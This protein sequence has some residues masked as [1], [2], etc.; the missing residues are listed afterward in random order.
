V[1]QGRILHLCGWDQKFVLS[2]RDL[3]HAHFA[4]GRHKFIIYGSVDQAAL[5]QS[6]DTVV[7]GSLLKNIF[8]LSTAMQ[9]AEKI[10]LHGLFS[11]HLLYV[12]ALQPWLLKKCHW[13]IW[14]GD[15]Y[16]HQAEVK[17]LRWKKN[18][19]FRRLVIQRLGYLLTYIPGDVALARQ[20]YGATGQYQEC[21]MY[22]SNIFKELVIP[23]KTGS[24]VNILVGNSADPTNNHL[25][26]FEKLA[27]FKSENIMI[28]CPLS[29]GGVDNDYVKQ[30]AEKGRA[31]FGDRFVA[32]T[33][34]MP[35]SKYLAF[36]GQIDIAVFAHK[37]QQGMGNTITL[38]GLGKKVYM[39]SDVTPWAVFN[40]LGVKVFDYLMLESIQMDNEEQNENRIE[41]KNY[42]SEATLAK[43]WLYVFEG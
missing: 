38:L 39:R 35:F 29:Y 21:L 6:M 37:R 18:E 26:V 32:L 1:I 31:M 28:Y 2:F 11:S 24:V 42:F 17:D 27:A 3:I 8:A 9:H 33:D 36:L 5:P 41:I 10:I 7:Y 4:D 15:L 13:V 23:P 19:F 43:Q 16:V 14:G 34:F 22:T 40:G 25:E 30:I 20:W 12:L